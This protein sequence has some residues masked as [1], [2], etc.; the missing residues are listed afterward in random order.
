MQV[1][2]QLY[3]WAYVGLII[4]HGLR[5][6]LCKSRQIFNIRSY[7]PISWSRPPAAD[8]ASFALGSANGANGVIDR[9]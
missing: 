7:D 8:L 3:K 6:T 5:N 4:K 1:D 9:S 2:N